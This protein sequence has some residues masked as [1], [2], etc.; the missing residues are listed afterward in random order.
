MNW[1]VRS[2]FT[3]YVSWM[4]FVIQSHYHVSLVPYFD[5]LRS[6]FSEKQIKID[7]FNEFFIEREYFV[8]GVGSFLEREH[9][10]KVLYVKSQ[11]WWLIFFTNVGQLLSSLLEELFFLFIQKQHS[12]QRCK[13][14]Y[15][16]IKWRFWSIKNRV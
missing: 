2:H 10:T 15:S 12:V 8:K 11:C 13:I 1:R 3:S 7:S 14:F 4:V 9:F 16:P 5:E 6:L